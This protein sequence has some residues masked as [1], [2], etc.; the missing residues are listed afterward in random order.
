ME[1]FGLMR[2]Y[3]VSVLLFA[4]LLSSLPV[5]VDA[6]VPDDTVTI[7]TSSPLVTLNPYSG[8]GGFGPTKEIQTLT[9]MG[10][11]YWSR[12]LQKVQNSQ[13]GSYAILTTSPLSVRFT[14]R[15]GAK[16]SDGV[17][18]TAVDL[19]F[20]HLVS[21]S[22]YAQSAGLIATNSANPKPTFDSINYG[23]SY[24]QSIVQAP[25]LSSD[26]QS[27]TLT[28]SKPF[29]DWESFTPTPFP[30]H[31]LALMS[32]GAIRIPSLSESLVAK[33]EFEAFFQNRV[34]GGL[35]KYADAFNLFYNIK[36]VNE[37]TNPLLLVANGPY[38]LEFA[39]QNN[40]RLK[41]NL[42]YNSGPSLSGIDSVHYKILPDGNDLLNAAK[43]GEVDIAQGQATID[44]AKSYKDIT[45]NRFVSYDNAP[46]EHLDLRV[47]PGPDGGTYTGPFAGN[48]SKARD[49]RSAFLLAFPREEILREVIQPIAPHAILPTSLFLSESESNHD[50]LS[51]QSGFLAKYS[52]DDLSRQRAALKIVKSYFPNATSSN[53]VVDVKILYGTTQ[54]SR[55]V[56]LIQLAK[57]A[58]AKSGFNL[59]PD[60]Q[61]AWSSQLGNSKYDAH[62]FA[63][64]W[65]P[66]RSIGLANPYCTNCVNNY[67][68]YS[69]Q[70]VD[71][72][73]QI[74]NSSMLSAQE[75]IK[76]II[77]IETQ[78]VSDAVSIPL[79]RQPAYYSVNQKLVNFVPS[80]LPEGYLWNFWEW[81]KSTASLVDY[82]SEQIDESFALSDGLNA[83]TDDADDLNARVQDDL[84]V[85]LFTNIPTF[86]DRLAKIKRKLLNFGQI[87]TNLK[88]IY[89]S[90]CGF[91]LKDISNTDQSNE[92]IDVCNEFLD[93]V[94]NAKYNFAFTDEATLSAETYLVKLKAANAAAD[95][96]AKEE[97]TTKL[98]TCPASVVGNSSLLASTPDV[99]SIMFS[100][101]NQFLQRVDPITLEVSKN[102]KGIVGCY[103]YFSLNIGYDAL[104]DIGVVT[105]ENSKYEWLNAAGARWN[106]IPDFENSRFKTDKTNPYFNN[107]SGD[108]FVFGTAISKQEADAKAAADLKAKQEADAKAAADLKAKQE[109]D[110]KAAA[111][112]KAKQ[113]ADAKAAA[114]L[115][116][117][118]EA[119]AKA[120][121]EL[122]A[123]LEADTK[124]AADLRAKLEADVKA[125]ADAKAA[126]DL[127]AKQEADAKATADQR[128]KQEADAKAAADLRAKQEADSKAAA[129]KAAAAKAAAAKAAAAKAKKT[130]KA[131]C[132]KGTQNRPE[133]LKA[134]KCPAGWVKK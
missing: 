72:N 127:R 46:F 101:T 2:R 102:S 41:K 48:S 94:E 29:P 129:A 75:K 16:W 120:A 90:N 73:Y 81:S 8:D 76:A 78:L 83:Y 18:I 59:I 108:N 37:K 62:L 79:F 98:P 96:K 93:S 116:A 133:L 12:T 65:R 60:V 63:W 123:K 6:A 119:D 124:A 88:E 66:S 86:L 30:V 27:L 14:V 49:L 91:A 69:N 84:E 118:Q 117:K 40:I 115:K 134:G 7:A 68:G 5:K 97:A 100:I 10:F 22:V 47:G 39:D 44:G 95:L 113:E 43:S 74:L 35:K 99:L 58:L 31:A 50:E 70:I 53:P 38:Q 111:D 105:Y 52:D 106:L 128:A 26:K 131:T 61:N 55:R 19:L 89:R 23:N 82:I 109:A 34:T 110:A 42:N 56:A 36:E 15:N 11:S 33:S 92:A 28:Y 57:V 130:S 80:I 112:L 107:G 25:V 103:K 1:R 3:K 4:F 45:Q 54:N 126:A 21:S 51:L 13:F 114:A 77:Q 20:S 32:T 17:P 9:S 67:L 87:L 85:N 24:D 71:Q 125:A 132:M 121:A 64:V 122:R 104:W